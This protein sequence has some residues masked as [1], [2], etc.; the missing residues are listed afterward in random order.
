MRNRVKST[1][2][3]DLGKKPKK[4]DPGVPHARVAPPWGSGDLPRRRPH[5][6][7][8]PRTRSGSG[9]N[10]PPAAPY[11]TGA[12]SGRPGGRYLGGEVFTAHW[13]TPKG[14]TPDAV[15]SDPLDADARST[16]PP[17][18]PVS[19]H[20]NRCGGSKRFSRR[21]KGGKNDHDQTPGGSRAPPPPHARL[22]GPGL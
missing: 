12:A 18:L 19:G 20:Q 6:M 14:V 22:G 13:S 10:V 15:E 4:T 8:P 3:L 2:Q 17:G 16:H 9:I 11:M 5:R 7:G 21:R 1:T